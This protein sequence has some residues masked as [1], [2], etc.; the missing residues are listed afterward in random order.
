[1]PN[2]SKINDAG[3]GRRR[4]VSPVPDPSTSFPPARPYCF[5]GV[6]QRV[7]R[8]EQMR[9]WIQQKQMVGFAGGNA[10]I[11]CGG[12]SAIFA[13][14]DQV[15]VCLLANQLHRSIA[16]SVIDDD[17]CHVGSHLS[18]RFQAWQ[19]DGFRVE[20]HDDCGDSQK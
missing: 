8:R 20:G 12:E 4:M 18:K 17:G 11:D 15:D 6:H 16:R 19:D 9:V 13:I 1:M 7:N 10:L 5:A 2:S 3:V 14:R